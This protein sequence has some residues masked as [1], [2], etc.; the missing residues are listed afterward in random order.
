MPNVDVA[1]VSLDENNN[2]GANIV[3]PVG[4]VRRA[5]LATATLN[6][7]ENGNIGVFTESSGGGTSVPTN[8]SSTTLSIGG[9]GFNRTVNLTSEQIENLE[10]A[11]KALQDKDLLPIVQS[12]S[13]LEE[14]IVTNAAAISYTTKETD[15][16]LFSTTVAAALDELTERGNAANDVLAE[17]DKNLTALNGET[18]RI[19][20][21][22][23]TANEAIWGTEIQK[24]IKDG[25]FGQGLLTDL[26]LE[27]ASYAQGTRILT[28]SQKGGTT[29]AVALTQAS[30]LYDGLMTSSDV[31]SLR[32]VI[33]KVES[34]NSASFA[35][36]GTLTVTNAV[37]EAMTPAQQIVQVQADLGISSFAN[38]N[39]VKTS[40]NVT[41]VYENTLWV[42]WGDSPVNIATNTTLGIVKGDAETPGKVYVETDG[43]MSLIGYDALAER[44]NDQSEVLTY[45]GT[46]T[47]DVS[48]VDANGRIESISRVERTLPPLPFKVFATEQ[49]AAADMS[50]F[51]A[52]FPVE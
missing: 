11:G 8:I 14:S 6:I 17:T 2:V 39:A 20:N 36:I 7:D 9:S 30:D 38:N 12:I 34:L 33:S 44:T 51:L 47:S 32:E 52:L 13:K 18:V 49:E 42:R 16:P 31:E 48:E 43:T 4:T 25:A 5:P 37:F 24:G 10:L 23:Q 50:G 29:A 41:W 3:S 46:F 15:R 26:K 21:S 35:P 27:N 28:V 19:A 22:L 45:G 40:D 1:Q